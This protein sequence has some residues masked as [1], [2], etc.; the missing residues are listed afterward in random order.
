L[1]PLRWIP[2]FWP[3]LAFVLVLSYAVLVLVLDRWLGDRTR[4][5][6]QPR[7]HR[8]DPLEHSFQFAI[9]IIVE[10]VGCRQHVLDRSTFECRTAGNIEKATTIF[11][12]AFAV[13]FCDVQWDLLRS[14]EPLI[15]SVAMSAV[16]IL[17]DGE[18]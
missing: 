18:R 12:A 13:A 4:S 14:T 9:A 17:G 2:W 1:P 15:A 11:E 7:Q 6:N 16:E 8:H 10:C 5:R 3:V